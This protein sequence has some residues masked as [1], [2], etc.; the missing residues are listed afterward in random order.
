MKI[1]PSV[2]RSATAP[3]GDP[4]LLWRGAEGLGLASSAVDP[5]ERARLLEAGDR[6]RFRHPLVRTAI[7]GAASAEDRRR[8]H[9]ALA[10]ATDA[11]IDA[12]RRAWHLAEA[13]AGVNDEVAAELEQAASRTQARGG[14]AAVG[15]FLTRSFALTSDPDRGTERAVA[16]AEASIGAGRFDA[17][18]RLLDVIESRPLT[19]LQRGRADLLRGRIAASVRWGRDATPLFLKAASRLEAVDREL[20]VEE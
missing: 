16:A 2:A 20:A 1:V 19:E 12:D 9:R 4:V 7:Y 3:V 15:A 10:E 11:A 6:V 18:R 17:A 8:A 14:L 13:T 5:A